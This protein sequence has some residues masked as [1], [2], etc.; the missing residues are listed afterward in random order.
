MFFV[1]RWVGANFPALKPVLLPLW[2]PLRH[3]LW[4]V[5]R[6]IWPK[7]PIDIP[8]A[9]SDGIRLMPEGQ[10][11]ELMWGLEFEKKERDFVS[12]NLMPGMH[13]VNIGANVG[14]YALMA[15]KLIG[16]SGKVYAFEPSGETFSV[17]KKNIE[18]NRCINIISEN[19]ALSDFS[20]S[21]LLRSDPLA[22][23]A[24][25][26]R[27]V[28]KIDATNTEASDGEVVQCKTLDSYWNEDPE[29]SV[30][31]IDMMI[32]DVEGAELS[33]LKG[34]VET[35]QRS[36]N[37]TLLLECTENRLE[38]KDFLESFGF[39]FFA[40]NSQDNQLVP[41]DFFQAVRCGDVIA[42]RNKILQ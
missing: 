41:C 32:I 11:A 23:A 22:P 9:T 26:H 7:R 6:A 39:E 13:V 38:V 21:L 18:L 2:L 28:E 20:G 12:H 34:A 33:V 36:P 19:M 4:L 27:Y 14:L 31:S 24:D 8:I 1:T 30:L 40:W 35:I 10:I 37:L 42:R 15:S 16:L 25:G 17:L 3:T 29:R 5:R